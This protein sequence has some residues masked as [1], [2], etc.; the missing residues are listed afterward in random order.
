MSRQSLG[1]TEEARPDND[2]EECGG[3][4][5]QRGMRGKEEQAF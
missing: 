5:G 2:I 3:R 1:D 4:K